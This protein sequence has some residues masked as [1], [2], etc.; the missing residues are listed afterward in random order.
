VGAK[1]LGSA[2]SVRYL[3]IIGRADDFHT[4]IS[5]VKTCFSRLMKARKLLQLRNLYIICMLSN[6]LIFC[7]PRAVPNLGFFRSKSYE[8]LVFV[9]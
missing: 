4:P 9:S 2:I 3:M 6:Y 5:M 7:R 8:A 1:C